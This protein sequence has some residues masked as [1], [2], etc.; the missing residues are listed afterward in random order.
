LVS[1]YSVLSLYLVK[2]DF[3]IV[4]V[5]SEVEESEASE[6]LK[7]DVRKNTRQKKIIDIEVKKKLYCYFL[8]V[9]RLSRNLGGQLQNWHRGNII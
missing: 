7:N 1:F 5:A 9:F 3:K 4:I 6:K 8:R 2:Y